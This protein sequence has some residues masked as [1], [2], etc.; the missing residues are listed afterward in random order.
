[1]ETGTHEDPESVLRPLRNVAGAVTALRSP[2]LPAEEARGAI[3]QVAA[4]VESSLRRLLRDLPA[5]ALQVRLRALAPDELGADEVLAE[6]RQHDRISMELAAAVHDLFEARQRLRGGTAPS[7]PDA[8][9]AYRVADR[10]EHEVVSPRPVPRTVPPVDA[11][12]AMDETIMAPPP[13]R[14]PLSPFADIPRRWLWAGGGLLA[15]LVVGLGIWLATPRDTSQLQQGITLFR[16]GAYEDAASY[17]YRY[18]QANPDDA[19]PHLYL[20]RIHRRTRR[21]DLARDALA[22]ALDLAPE[23]AGVHTELGWL[24]LDTGHPAPAVDRFRKAVELGPE[25]EMAWAGLVRALRESGRGDAADRALGLAPPAIRQRLSRPGPAAP[26]AAAA[27]A[28]GSA[29]GAAPGSF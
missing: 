9:L 22:K 7:A 21:V 13:P 27:G 1:M 11:T 28:P 18:S 24:L 12:M 10:L 2:S 15:L 19:T 16:S 25:S 29:A 6:L 4:A 26:G 3:V 8:E 14:R 20:A 17:F 23:D 5:A